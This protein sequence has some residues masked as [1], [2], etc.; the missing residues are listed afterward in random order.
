M[1]HDPQKP[2]KKP[3]FIIVE[4]T[5]EYL[6]GDGKHQ[7]TFE[8][9]FKSQPEPQ[10]KQLSSTLF[11]RLCSGMSAF[12]CFWVM[13]VSFISAAVVLVPAALLFFQVDKMNLMFLRLWKLFKVF[14]TCTLGFILGVFNPSLGIGFIMLYFSLKSEAMSPFM[15]TILKRMSDRL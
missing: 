14:L 1:E 7:E 9:F 5:R 12:I 15:N 8:E 11:F 13:V 3:E 6:Q 2:Y 4:D 10:P